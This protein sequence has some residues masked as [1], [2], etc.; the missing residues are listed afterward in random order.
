MATEKLQ[1]ISV[2]IKPEILRKLD[3]LTKRHEYYTRSSLMNLLLGNLLKC[4]SGGTLWKMISEY[5]PYE[6]GYVVKFEKDIEVLAERNK[7]TFDD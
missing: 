5:Y 2:R 4:A 7:P 1:L 6:K 3:E